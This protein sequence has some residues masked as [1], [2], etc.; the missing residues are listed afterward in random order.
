MLR[1]MD[2]K[3]GGL[4]YVLVFLYV[5]WIPSVNMAC[6]YSWGRQA[7]FWWIVSLFVSLGYLGCCHPE[8]PYVIVGKVFRW[9]LLVCMIA[10]KGLWVAPYSYSRFLD[11]FK[12]LIDGG[13]AFVDWYLCDE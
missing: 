13:C 9:L 10:F 6:C 12:Y 11:Y 8:Y 2:S 3:V 7:L 4:F 1:S 5:M